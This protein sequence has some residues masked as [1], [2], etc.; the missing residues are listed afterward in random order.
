MQGCMRRE[1]LE[2]AVEALIMLKPLLNFV[3]SNLVVEILGFLEL[4]KL[5]KQVADIALHA[6]K[7]E[8]S[9]DFF[10]WETLK[11]MDRDVKVG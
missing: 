9:L 5:T 8:L 10:A 3:D 1:H 11:L 7:Q 2:P 6:V 4:V